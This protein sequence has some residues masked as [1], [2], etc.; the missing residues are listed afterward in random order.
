MVGGN[1]GV[2]QMNSIIKRLT[3]LENK[4]PKYIMYTDTDGVRRH[5]GML[6]FL[7]NYTYLEVKEVLRESDGIF[8]DVKCAF[9][10]IP[11]GEYP[12]IA[13]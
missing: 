9:D 2:K 6:H 1:Q 12:A 11:I 10:S 3:T 4:S 13:D 8:A 7:M 5:M